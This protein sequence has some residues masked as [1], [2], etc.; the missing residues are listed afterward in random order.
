M[1]TKEERG[2]EGVVALQV[3]I[4]SEG[5]HGHHH[6]EGKKG[7]YSMCTH[8]SVSLTHNSVERRKEERKGDE[9]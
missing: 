8:I 7:H 6:N 4:L 3:T 2:F 5:S 9:G 1:H